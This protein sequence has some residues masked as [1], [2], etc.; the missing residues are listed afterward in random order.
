MTGIIN[1]VRSGM[2]HYN[3]DPAIAFCRH[4]SYRSIPYFIVEENLYGTSSTDICVAS[5]DISVANTGIWAANFNTDCT[6]CNTY[7]HYSHYLHALL[8]L[9]T[10]TICIICTH[11]LHYL[12]A[13]FVPVALFTFC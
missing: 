12:H 9:F 3:H 6:F 2:A 5:T 4:R 13:L 1:V 11:Y 10:C 7:M 8:A